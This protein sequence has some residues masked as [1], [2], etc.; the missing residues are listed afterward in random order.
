MKTLMQTRPNATLSSLVLGLAAA[1]SAIAADLNVPTTAYPTIQAAVNAAN[2]NDTI[3]IAPGVYTNQ[4]QITNKVLTLIGQPGTIL[5]ATAAMSAPPGT[6]N[7]PIIFI[8]LSQVTVR[9]LTFEGERL[10][11]RFVGDGDLRGILLRESSAIVENCAFYGFR[12]ST[13][14]PE[15][16]DALTA[17]HFEDF[18]TNAVNVRVVGC[19]FADNYTGVFF[20]GLPDRQ[21]M[22]VTIENNIIIGPGPLTG[23]NSHA[24]VMIGEGVGGRI[25]GNTISGYSYVG[26]TAA[27]PIS[28][29]ILGVNTA[30][31]PP[32]FGILQPLIVEGNTLR[33]NQWHIALVKG[34]NSVVKNNRC[35]GTA[36]GI[37]PVGMAVS[38]T[39]MTIAN[40]RFEDMPEGI[41]L[42]GNDPDYGTLLGAAINAQVTSNRFC[43]VT[44]NVTVQPLASATQ[45]GTLSICPIPPPP[46]AIAPA[47]LL[48][49][50]GE[51]PGWT[52]ES[53]TDL[54]GPWT[55]STATPF[56]QYG[57]HS[58]AVPTDGERQFFRLH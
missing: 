20:I 31:F 34:D 8:K 56:M 33:D 17:D 24:G 54:N 6:F 36:P 5:R 57:R 38:G 11:G 21:T 44:T 32:E 12:E 47:V 55:P 42:W 4:V 49:W 53:A 19:T 43:G 48:S 25:A 22:N 13:P 10:A 39:N 35:Q 3:H 15:G 45:T 14:G 16:A 7:F 37:R 41:R 23:D 2:T 46:L 1:A 40:N 51:A 30:N 58:I 18:D 52:V 27:F 28:W 9:G 26:T 29:G 50:P